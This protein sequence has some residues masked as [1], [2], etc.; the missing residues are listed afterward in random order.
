MK[1]YLL[2]LNNN[3]CT[4]KARIKDVKLIQSVNDEKIYEN[5]EVLAYETGKFISSHM[6]D[7]ITKKEI[8]YGDNV[9]GISYKSKIPVSKETLNKILNKYNNLTHEEINRYKKGIFEIEKNSIL[10]YNELLSN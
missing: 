5:I 6:Y 9:N 7:V 4:N 1:Y 8:F 10:K 3:E 2:Y